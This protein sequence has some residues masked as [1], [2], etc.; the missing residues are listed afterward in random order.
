[1]R[2]WFSNL[3]YKLSAFMQG[4]YGYD[5]LSRFL[6]IA[7][8]I[9][10]IISWFPHLHFLYI[11]GLAILIWS[12]TRTMSRNIYRRQT[13][14]NKYLYIKNRFAQKIRLIKNRWRDRKT[15]KYYRCPGC[16]T[17]VRIKKPQ[18]GKKILITCP[19]CGQSFEKRT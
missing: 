11:P 16:R 9:L 5:E 2:K 8:L 1:M 6:S 15:H 12:W 18:R 19:K 14:R 7:G 10:I 13:E 17:Y 3:G 4:R